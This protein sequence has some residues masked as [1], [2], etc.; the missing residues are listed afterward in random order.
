MAITRISDN[1]IA[2]TTNAVLDSLSFLDT[3]SILSLPAGPEDDRPDAPPFGTLRFN[4]DIDNAEIYVSDTGSGSAGWAAV[5]GGGPSLGADSVIRTNSN[6][7]EE[8]IT[9]GPSVDAKFTN[10]MSAGP[11]TI[12]NGWTVTVESGGAWS[13]V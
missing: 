2:D 3:E 5:A 9:V 12:A 7:I 6:T 4:S 1:Q 8:D 10:G 13:I 11:I